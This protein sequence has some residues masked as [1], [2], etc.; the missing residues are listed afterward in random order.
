MTTTLSSKTAKDVNLSLFFFNVGY[1]S[2]YW[3]TYVIESLIGAQKNEK[4]GQQKCGSEESVG[5]YAVN[6]RIVITV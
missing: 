2:K 5:L 4:Q 1:T 6:D 3:L